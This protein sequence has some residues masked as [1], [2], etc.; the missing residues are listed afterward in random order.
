MLSGRAEEQRE[1]SQNNP[2]EKVP[3]HTNPT[4]FTIYTSLQSVSRDSC[5]HNQ[6]SKRLTPTGFR[7]IGEKM[8]DHAGNG[9]GPNANEKSLDQWFSIFGSRISDIYSQQ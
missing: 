3:Q 2:H 9:I 6:P 4:R 7:F 5:G 8:G 1:E